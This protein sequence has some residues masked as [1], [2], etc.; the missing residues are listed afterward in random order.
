MPNQYRIPLVVW[1]AGLSIEDAKWVLLFGIL[2]V[3]VI[4]FMALTYLVFKKM[5]EDD[6]KKRTM[7]QELKVPDEKPESTEEEPGSKEGE[8]TKPEE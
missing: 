2:I 7:D 4:W 5:K 6:K 3:I 8:E 1:M